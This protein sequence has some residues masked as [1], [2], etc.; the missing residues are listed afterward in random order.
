MATSGS[1]LGAS[2]YFS[3][4]SSMQVYPMLVVGEII[5]PICNTKMVNSVAGGRLYAEHPKYSW[6]NC[7]NNGLTVQI[8]PVLATLAVP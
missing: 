5:C 7:Q 6:L 3:G 1:A 8:P 2:P 4:E